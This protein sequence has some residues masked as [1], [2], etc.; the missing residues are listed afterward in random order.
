M[1]YYPLCVM[2][3]PVP[4]PPK[5]LP[6]NKKLPKSTHPPPEA[7]KKYNEYSVKLNMKKWTHN[8]KPEGF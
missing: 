2:T 1:W 3:K 4:K 7:P 8:P 5:P 6:V